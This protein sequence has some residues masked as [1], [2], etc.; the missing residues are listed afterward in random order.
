MNWVISIFIGTMFFV[1]GQIC[2]RKS[3]ELDNTL[4]QTF[5]LF[6]GTIGIM[7]IPFLFQHSLE[8]KQN[9]LFPILAGLFFFI[10]NFFWIKTISSKES[11]G[12]IRVA[13]AG[14]E[15]ILLFFVSYLFFSDKITLYQFIGSLFILLGIALAS[16]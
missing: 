9:W 15:T 8:K 14:F 4:L 5:L 13:M 12:L 6:T 1:M 2:L 16:F 7:T 3:F 10:G 11:L